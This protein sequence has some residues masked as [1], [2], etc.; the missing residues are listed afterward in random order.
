MATY[1]VSFRLRRTITETAF[2]SVPVTGYLIQP[3]PSGA[4][5]NV[6]KMVQAAIDMGSLDSTN[7][8]VEGNTLIELHPTQTRPEPG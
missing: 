6:D 7:W 2:V 8:V 4:L 5:L 3:G 1:S